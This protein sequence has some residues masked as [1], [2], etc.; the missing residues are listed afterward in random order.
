MYTYIYTCICICICRYIYTYTY[1]YIYIHTYTYIYIYTHTHTHTYICRCASCPLLTTQHTNV[2]LTTSTPS[3]CDPRTGTYLVTYRATLAGE[4]TLSL[5]I[6]NSLAPETIYYRG[7]GLGTL[8]VLPAYIA[9]MLGVAGGEEAGTVPENTF[10]T[11]LENTFCAVLENISLSLKLARSLSLSL[12]LINTHAHTNTV[13]SIANWTTR[14]TVQTKDE[15]G[16]DR[17]HGTLHAMRYLPQVLCPLY[18][19]AI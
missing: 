9:P 12:S 18:T 19:R 5:L 11:V 17:R 15:F 8:D 14:I 6:N 4:Y 1:I 3:A 10:C 7:V 2:T 13:S 16:N